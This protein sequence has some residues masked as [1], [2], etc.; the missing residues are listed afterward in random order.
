[1][2]G[3]SA[4]ILIGSILGLR[5]RVMTF[6]AAMAV[7]AVSVGVILGAEEASFASGVAACAITS[8]GLQIGYVLGILGR[9]MLEAR[10]EPRPVALRGDQG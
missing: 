6:L 2:L 5:V 4:T 9:F 1:M 7:L 8:F 3:F 10:L